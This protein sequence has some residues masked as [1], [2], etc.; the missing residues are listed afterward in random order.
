MAFEL[1]YISIVR[2]MDTIFNLYIEDPRQQNITTGRKETSRGRLRVIS[3]YDHNIIDIFIFLAR[4]S[5][6]D[7]LPLKP[8]LLNSV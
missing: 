2:E 6:K 8:L 3:F 4:I 7:S 1:V 5:Y